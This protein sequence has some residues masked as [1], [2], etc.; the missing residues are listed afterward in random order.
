MYT[1]DVNN[2]NVVFSQGV[3]VTNNLTV[4]GGFNYTPLGVIWQWG[5]ASAPAGFLICD[6]SAISRTGFAALFATIGIVY[7][8]TTFRIP[9]LQSRV[10]VGRNTGDGYFAS[11]G[12]TGG[13]T[14]V[15]LGLN[16]MPSHSHSVTDTGHNHSV[17]DYGHAHEIYQLW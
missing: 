11:L 16:H 13:A 12:F 7:G 14:S 6:G 2:G 3:G 1:A 9:N 17:N 5:G 4:S 8:S 15:Q 10:A